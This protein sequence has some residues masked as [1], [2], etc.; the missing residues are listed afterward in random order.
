MLFIQLQ[1]FIKNL[2][3]AKYCKSSQQMKIKRTVHEQIIQ[4]SGNKNTRNSHYNVLKSIT[5]V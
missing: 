5:K 2:L 3:F 4:M 1:I